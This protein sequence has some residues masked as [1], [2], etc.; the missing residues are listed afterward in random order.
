MFC[1]CAHYLEKLLVCFALASP[2]ELPSSRAHGHPC[3]AALGRNGSAMLSSYRNAA[4]AAQTCAAQTCA[5][6][7]SPMQNGRSRF[8]MTAEPIRSGTPAFRHTNLAMFS[9]GFS[10]FSLVY[11]VQPVMPVFSREF[12]VSPAASSLSVSLTSGLLAVAILAAGSLSEAWGRK[13]VMVASLFTS[14]ILT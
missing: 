12:H 7:N 9:A 8:S 13:P 11:C 14:A 4:Y 10:T 1:L 5:A 2:W 3:I 6:Q